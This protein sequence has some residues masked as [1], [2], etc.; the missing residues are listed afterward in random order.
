MISVSGAPTSL[1]RQSRHK[2]GQSPRDWRHTLRPRWLS[3]LTAWRPPSIKKSHPH[4]H[5]YPRILGMTHSLQTR[6]HIFLRTPG[7]RPGHQEMKWVP[8]MLKCPK[9]RF[10]AFVW[11]TRGQDSVPQRSKWT[12]SGR[13]AGTPGRSQKPLML[14]GQLIYSF[15]PDKPPS[16]RLISTGHGDHMGCGDPPPFPCWPEQDRSDRQKSQV[17]SSHSPQRRR[18]KARL[19]DVSLMPARGAGRTRDSSFTVFPHFRQLLTFSPLALSLGDL[20]SPLHFQISCQ[21]IIT[22]LLSDWQALMNYWFSSSTSRYN[23]FMLERKVLFELRLVSFD[24]FPFKHNTCVQFWLESGV[25]SDHSYWAWGGRHELP[26]G[27]VPLLTPSPWDATSL[28][29]M[30]LGQTTQHGLDRHWAG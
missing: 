30:M 26:P 10:A 14:P 22:H 11:M 29:A 4:R 27:C 8:Q 7:G 2:E 16:C 15:L 19:I 20:F 9:W 24:S 5:L 28:P 21:W 12:L 13:W 23:I 6:R 18:S 17:Q 3:P 1:R 25:N